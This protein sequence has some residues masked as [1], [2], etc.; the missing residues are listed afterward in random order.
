[1]AWFSKKPRIATPPEP[2]EAPSRMQGLWAKCEN[3]DEI[4]YGGSYTSVMQFQYSNTNIHFYS[5][6]KPPAMVMD[7]K[8]WL[9][10]IEYVNGQPHLFG[11]VHYVGEP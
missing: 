7:W 11:T 5:V 3:C 10:R 1:M 6:I 8:V 9:V 2:I 4:I